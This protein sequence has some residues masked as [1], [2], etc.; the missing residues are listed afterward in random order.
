MIGKEF[1]DKVVEEANFL[2]NAGMLGTLETCLYLSVGSLILSEDKKAIAS[3][4]LHMKRLIEPLALTKIEDEIDEIE[5][6]EGGREA[7]MELLKIIDG[8][9]SDEN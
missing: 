6:L 9:G 5:Y 3:A 1:A 2:R 4:L 7:E 8:G